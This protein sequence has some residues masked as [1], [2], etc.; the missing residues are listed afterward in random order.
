MARV[1]RRCQKR[2][3]R[4]KSLSKEKKHTTLTSSSSLPSKAS[5]P[6][7]SPVILRSQRRR[8]SS[9]LLAFRDISETLKHILAA[10]VSWCWW[11]QRHVAQILHVFVSAAFPSHTYLAEL[12][13][14]RA[15]VEN[16][17]REV[18]E[19]QSVL[20]QNGG[21]A[22]SAGTLPCQLSPNLLSASAHTQLSV[23]QPTPLP[24]QNLQIPTPP[25]PPPPPPLPPPPPPPAPLVF[26]RR[27]DP[28]I[29]A[30]PLK[31]D[32][33]LQITAQ[34]LLNVKLKKTKSEAATDKET[35]PSKGRKALIT[36]RDLQSIRLQAN[37]PQPLPRVTNFLNTPSRD[38]L[39]FR[40]HLKKVAIK[41][42]P[43]GTPMNNKENIE[44]GTGLTPLMTQALR[45][46]FQL[47]HP[48][49]PSPSCF[50]T[51]NSFEEQS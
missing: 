21:T 45:R 4:T 16:L 28:K 25:P 48:K 14:L 44:T 46:K 13:E 22:A 35:S 1:K 18:A 3:S 33:P 51:R 38:G 20:Q 39:D 7:R 15:E 27:S 41:R 42:S 37:A 30:V 6:T 40:K 11:C 2:R 24:S 9:W 43:G 34:D 19:L 12:K 26:K 31:K 23:T 36:L 32:V 17:K 47:A 29:Q 5:P 49:S 8:F 10:A 50:P